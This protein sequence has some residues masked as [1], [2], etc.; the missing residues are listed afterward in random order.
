MDGPIQGIDFDT[1]ARSNIVDPQ[2]SGRATR[3]RC[4]NPPQVNPTLRACAALALVTIVAPPAPSSPST[5]PVPATPEF[6]SSITVVTVPVFVTDRAGKA[7]AGLTAEDFQV[8][9]DGKPMRLVGVR[10]FDAAAPP[11]PEAAGSPAAHRQ[12]LLLFDLSFSGINGLVRSQKAALE[13]V[14]HRLEPGDLAAVATFS[15]NHGVRLL[16]GFTSDRFQ[17]RRALRTL[18]VLQLDAHADPLGLAFDLRDLGSSIAD[19]LPEERGDAVSESV[20]AIQ[21]R[22]ERA[23]EAVYRQRI[24]ALLD[25]MRQ[26]ALALDVMQ[27]RKQVIYFSNGF[28]ATALEGQGG[29]QQMKDSDSI[30]RGRLWEVS[31]ENRFGDT[32]IRQEMAQ[33]LQAFSSSDSLV[34]AVDLAGLSARGDVRQ[35][36]AEPTM[37]SG[38]ASLSEMARLSGGRLFRNTNDPGEALTEIAEMSRHYYLLAFEPQQAR[39]S[40]KFHKLKIQ[41]RGKDRDLSHRSG[42]F[43]RSAY[44][45][46]PPMARRFEA[47]EII[48][49]GLDK[50][51]IP[52]R[53]IGLPYRTPG[54]PVTVPFVLEADGEAVLRGARGGRVG[55]EIYGYALDEK[56]AVEDL[57]ALSSTLEVEA[58]APRLRGR[59]L[60]CH[61]TFTLAPGRHSLRFLVRDA[62]GRTGARGLDITVPSFD[63]SEVLLFPPLVM[64]EP[65]DWLILPAPSRSTPHP[66]S[67]FHVAAEAFTPRARPSLANGRTDRV[68]L[69]AFD[70][71]QRYDPGAAFEIKPQLV[72]ASGAAVRLGRI[73][74]ARSVADPD[75]FRRFVLN[76]TPA[77]LVAGDYTL[78]VRLRDPASGRISEAYQ[79]LRVE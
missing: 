76:V 51:E 44:A 79:A 49:K 54:G 17:L 69:L 53:V 23:Q 42:Y 3:R 16:V 46:R 72:D 37:R 58:T 30:S 28:D 52:L 20:R 65:A 67:P 66:V 75:G 56:G 29:A 45:E 48:A 5:P 61:A 38:L 21:I 57:V 43:E 78:R 27:G 71:G 77:D 9:D 15:A 26:L 41:V 40:G 13:F 4:H 55:L 62:S 68:F 73:E 25:G 36:T 33:M 11:P 60:Q 63:P 2:H 19:T 64:D 10:E 34:H 70:G 50:D 12:F 22:Y 32:Q 18:G 6:A 59:G 24:L 35:Q 39:G 8:F 14:T 1:A 31:S 47:A 7:V 74:V